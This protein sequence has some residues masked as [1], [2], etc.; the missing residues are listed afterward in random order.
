MLQYIGVS[1]WELGARLWIHAR[2]W[3]N[4]QVVSSYTYT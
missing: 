1:E 3:E 2:Y 4:A